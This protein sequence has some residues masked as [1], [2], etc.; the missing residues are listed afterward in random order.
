[1]HVEDQPIYTTTSLKTDEAERRGWA[2][3][4]EGYATNIGARTDEAV[5]AL[6]S[7]T[8][9]YPPS[10]PTFIMHGER[11]AKTTRRPQAT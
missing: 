1:M 6:P 11:E 3:P 2:K 10:S 7:P 9:I 5:D 4:M 8:Y